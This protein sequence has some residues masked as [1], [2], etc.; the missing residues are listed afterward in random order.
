MSDEPTLWEQLPD[1]DDITIG[2]LPYN[3][4]SGWSG[5]DTSLARAIDDDTSGR[6][7]ERQQATLGSLAQAGDLGLTYRELGEIHGWHHGQSSGALSVLHK[8]GRVARLTERR[9]RCKVYVLPEHV[10]DRHT[11]PHGGSMNP[12]DG[13]PREAHMMTEQQASVLI[14][15]HDILVESVA[16]TLTTDRQTAERAINAVAD[17]LTGY[18]PTEFGDE[19]CSPIDTAAFILRRGETRD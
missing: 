3:G 8:T 7:S 15:G 19:Y 10:N 6:T 14:D 16:R 11:E 4:T 9:N 12:R 18:R 17:W 2:A 1:D 5:S 13:N